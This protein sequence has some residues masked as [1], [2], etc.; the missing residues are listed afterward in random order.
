[1]TLRWRVALLAAAIILP[2]PASAGPLIDA[3]SSSSTAAAVGKTPPSDDASPMEAFPGPI[4]WA[5]ITVG[6]AFAGA[7]LYIHRRRGFDAD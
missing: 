1:M 6:V 3:G 5:L 7:A 4:H 2:L